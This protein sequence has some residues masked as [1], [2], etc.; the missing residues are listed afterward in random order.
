VPVRL[1]DIAEQ[2]E[3]SEA[4]VSR[5]LN[6][7]PGIGDETRERVLRVAD[8]LGHRP[9]PTK[10]RR[11]TGS[12]GII[13]PELDNPIFPA[14]VQALGTQLAVHDLVPLV[15]SA[16][17]EGVREDD[18]VEAMSDRGVGGFIFVSGMHADEGS[19]P[20]RYQRLLDRGLGVVLV[21]GRHPGVEAPSVQCDEAHAAA[22]AVEHLVSLGHRRIGC[23]V[24]PRRYATSRHRVDGFTAATERLLEPSAGVVEETVFTVEGGHVAGGH[25]IDAGVTA[26]VAA[27]DLMALGA[28]RAAH[29][30]EL[31]VPSDISI[32]GYDGAPITAFTDPAL[33]TARQPWRAMAE[34]TVRLLLPQLEGDPPSRADHLSFRSDLVVR[35]STG[36]APP[37][38]RRTGRKPGA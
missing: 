36:P 19:D 15:G 29:D 24:G 17:P 4:T 35:R 26:I 32:V 11:R 16:T 18:Y 9:G 38:R 8:Q 37:R 2:A 31:G 12:V 22:A 21:N 30:R 13:V 27:S 5:V 20:A 1:R 34:A 28:I 25:L 14:V 10:R 7:R 6:G 3:V 23:A 33:T